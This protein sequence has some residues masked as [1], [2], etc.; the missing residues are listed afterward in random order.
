MRFIP[1]LLLMFQSIAAASSLEQVEGLLQSES[2]PEGVVFEIIE[3][4]DGLRW[5]IPQVVRYS[6]QLRQRFPDLSIAVVSHG[7]EQ[8]ALQS[9]ARD[10]FSEVH[11]L[12]QQLGQQQD[13]PVHVCGTHAG[14]YGVKPEDFPDYVDVAPTGPAQIRAYEELGYELIVIQQEPENHN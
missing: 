8:F 11:T 2:P 14:W 9:E 12:V 3:E 6:E 10:D 7:A 1:L 5:A 13:I 4:S